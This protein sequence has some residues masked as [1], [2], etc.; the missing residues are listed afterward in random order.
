MIAADGGDGSLDDFAGI[1]LDKN[2]ITLDKLYQNA[3]PGSDLN[4]SKDEID[5]FKKL[6]KKA[7]HE[8]IEKCLR[9]ILLDRFH[10]YKK[11]GLSGIKPYA[12]SKKEFSSGNELKYQIEVGPIL[13]KHSPIFH[14]YAMEYPNNKPD[15]AEESFF[16]VNSIIDE[17]PT[18][19]LVHRLGMPQ[20]GGWVY[21]ERHFYISRSHNCLQGIGAALPVD[22]GAVVFY[23]T[24][25]STDQV[26]GFGGAAKRT[27]GNRI[28]GGR[29]AAN[30]E[31]ARQVVVTAK[32]LDMLK[33]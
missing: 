11:D 18:I 20:D 17:K 30:F 23:A 31:R 26:S 14:K 7:S 22:D 9:Q 21:L 15:G 8:D 25:T 6:G 2:A 16:W 29:M 12:R 27:I 3:A 24:R 19:A 4:L 13:K 33:L 10:A 1:K 32:E 28:M 5:K